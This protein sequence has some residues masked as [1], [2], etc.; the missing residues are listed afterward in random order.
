M[1]TIEAIRTRRSIRK[2][3]DISVSPEKIE[4]VLEAGM[5]APSARNEQPWHFMVISDEALKDKLMNAHPYAKM[6][7][8]API[9]ILVCADKNLEL[10]PG[11]WPIDCSA[12]TQNI[13]LAAHASGLGAVWLGVHP[14]KEREDAI[15]KI[16]K[17]PHNIEP[18]SLI[19]LGY[20]NEQKEAQSRF[21]ASRVHYNS[22]NRT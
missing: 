22:W 17:L 6:L 9:A 20:P 8:E 1:D 21:N 14:R 2:F 15:R 5:Y 4:A 19:A 18:F 12:A 11:Y 13:L 7:K 10:S 3:K 16:L